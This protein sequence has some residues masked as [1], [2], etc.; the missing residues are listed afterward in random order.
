M[1]INMNTAILGLDGKEIPE[2]NIGKLIAQVLVQGSKGDA[3]KFWHW[4]QKMYSGEELDLDP[5]DTEILK[6]AIKENESLTILA[7]AQALACF[8]SKT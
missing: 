1:K 2:S 5:T 3:L 4:A 6:N 7:K 8:S